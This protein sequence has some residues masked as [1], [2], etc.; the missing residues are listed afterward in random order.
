MSSHVKSGQQLTRSESLG[1]SLRRLREERSLLLREAAAAVA[2]DS[3]I[4]SKVEL[5]HRFVT[6]PQ[7]VALA[8]FYEVPLPPLEARRLAAELKRQYGDHPAFAEA[9]A[10]VREEA[11]EYR[12]KK[13]PTT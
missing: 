8:Q 9:S 4:L 2:M 10:I 1:D 11:G 12:V 3:A 5:G 13:M 6:A 7:L